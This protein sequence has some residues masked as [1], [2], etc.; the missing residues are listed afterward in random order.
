MKKIKAREYARQHRMSLFQVIKKIQKGE[1]RGEQIE[2]NGV[3]VQYVLLDG[4]SEHAHDR[5][6]A[7]GVPV[8][9]TD[10][11]TEAEIA[12]ELRALRREIALLR[13]ELERCCRGT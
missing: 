6:P 4:E 1:L 3:N 2:E 5:I 8:R 7:S 12:E 10:P 13:R 9:E 11:G